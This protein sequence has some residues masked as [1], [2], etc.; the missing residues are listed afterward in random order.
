MRCAIQRVHSATT[1]PYLCMRLTY[2]GKYPNTFS[3]NYIHQSHLAVQRKGL[4][5][6]T[7]TRTYDAMNVAFDMFG[8]S[9]FKHSN[10]L[11][12]RNELDNLHF[13]ES[14]CTR[15]T[16]ITRKNYFCHIY[17]HVCTRFIHII[18]P[19]YRLD[20]MRTSIGVGAYGLDSSFR[21]F[22]FFFFVQ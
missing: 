6:P 11:S 1:N 22:S 8:F 5:L 16:K 3:R 7:H 19:M 13:V 2:F 9:Q 20:I 14:N 17:S 15:P 21:V 10:R 18:V 4:V 12:Q